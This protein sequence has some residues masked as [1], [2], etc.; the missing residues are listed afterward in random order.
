MAHSLIS[1]KSRP[2]SYLLSQAFPDHLLKT[3]ASVLPRT[4]LVLFQALVFFSIALFAPECNTYFICICLLDAPKQ[5][6][7]RF[8]LILFAALSPV[9]R[10]VSDAQKHPGN[11][12][13]MIESMSMKWRSW[14]AL[15]GGDVGLGPAERSWTFR[16]ME[17]P[18][19][20]RQNCKCHEDQA[21]V[22]SEDLACSRFLV[23]VC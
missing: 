18:L 21:G 23:N 14:L 8:L 9:P 12:C 1:L 22:A 17:C 7:Q 10:T 16:P 6:A 13:Q 11:V 4:P 3:A 5:A 2:R 20:V 15:H 19:L